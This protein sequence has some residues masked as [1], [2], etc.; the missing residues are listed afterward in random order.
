MN[1][2]FIFNLRQPCKNRGVDLTQNS[3]GSINIDG[4]RFETMRECEDFLEKIPRNDLAYI[5]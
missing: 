2:I 4:N 3:D 1:S 5:T